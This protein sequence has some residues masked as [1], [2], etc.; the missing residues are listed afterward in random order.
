VS[1]LADLIGGIRL[2]DE[3]APDAGA[4]SSES[5]LV[6]LLGKLHIANE[7]ASDL[8]SVGSTDPPFDMVIDADATPSDAFPGDVV[9]F[10]DPLPVANS[11]A[12]TGTVTE[13][14]VI[15][16]YGASSEAGRDPLQA[17]MRDLSAPIAPG[18][19]GETLEACRIAL[20]DSANKLAAM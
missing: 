3:P 18:V 14:L 19:N 20:L 7:P 5:C 1:C 10:D 12:S 15:S 11:N 16:H 6:D 13:V 4:A 9:I 17:A 2:P 8:E